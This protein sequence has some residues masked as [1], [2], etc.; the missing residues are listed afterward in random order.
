M[1]VTSHVRSALCALPINDLPWNQV[2]WTQFVVDLMETY[3]VQ[4]IM[5]SANRELETIGP[6][7]ITPKLIYHIHTF[8]APL[9]PAL[10]YKPRILG[11]H[12]L[13]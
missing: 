13:V 6:R 2:Q 4:T 11:S 3:F 9:L 10:D 8:H 1:L 12:F 7:A 5:F